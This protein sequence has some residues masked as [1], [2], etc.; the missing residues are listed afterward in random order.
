MKSKENSIK[1]DLEN[2]YKEVSKALPTEGRKTLLPSIKTGV[3]SY[4][5]ENPGATIDD[6]ISYV[7]TPECIANE[8]YA[9]LD[10]RRITDDIKVGK[11]I[12]MILLISAAIIVF[13]LI[14]AV[15]AFLIGSSI[16][17]SRFVQYDLGA[18]SDSG[19]LIGYGI[20]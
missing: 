3:N 13:I 8:Y 9:N 12:G 7:G 6:V 10:G 4:L 17:E 20:I 15:V 16:I 5:A 1:K 11:K 2:Y 19:L 18:V 14:V